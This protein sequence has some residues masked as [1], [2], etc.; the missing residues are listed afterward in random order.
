MSSS[1]FQ[2]NLTDT[3]KVQLIGIVLLAN[4]LNVNDSFADSS[5]VYSST[6]SR[7][8][9]VMS[10][11][12]F[13]FC[14]ENIIVSDENKKIGIEAEAFDLFGDMREATN[15]EQYSVNEYVE[16][17]SQSTGINFFEI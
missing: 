15:E 6:G 11:K 17:I 14:N 4:V 5:S 1:P 9:S 12:S 13:S 2:R 3:V 8:R 10:S 7:D 16:S